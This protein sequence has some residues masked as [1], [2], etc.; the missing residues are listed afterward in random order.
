MMMNP[1][2]G[3]QGRPTGM[4][5]AARPVM[6]ATKPPGPAHPS[7]LDANFLASMS[8]EQQK[9]VLGERLYTYIVKKHPKQAAKIT[10]M[11]LEM[12]N[13]EILNLLDSPQQ[14]D[15]KVAEAMD[16]LERH[17]SRM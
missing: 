2:L 9:N 5:Q 7:G 4:P 15:A 14:L 10:G 16:V 12:D 17:D 11:L 13:S 3:M 8:P 1:A 6:A